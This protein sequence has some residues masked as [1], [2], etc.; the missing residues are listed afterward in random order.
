M[1]RS[2]MKMSSELFTLSLITFWAQFPITTSRDF[3]V[4]SSGFLPSQFLKSSTDFN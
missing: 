4:A 3:L 1:K 2:F